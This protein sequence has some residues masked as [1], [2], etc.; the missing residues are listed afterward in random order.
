MRERMFATLGIWAAAA[1]V[2]D[3][4]MDGLSYTVTTFAEPLEQ[5][6]GETIQT[7][8]QVIYNTEFVSGIMQ[9]AI[10]GLIF[11]A[12]IC[13]T[14]ATV[15]IWQSST[16]AESDQ[17]R[18]VAHAAAK[19]KRSRELRVKRLLSAMDE[20]KLA[21]LEEQHLNEDEMTVAQLI[22]QRQKKQ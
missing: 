21:A 10:F 17:Q 8:P 20:D 1:F 3:R 19:T 7:I 12:L 14:G 6:F 15:V 5:Q 18:A 22:Q 9:I 16:A 4:L 13:A 11:M 2:A